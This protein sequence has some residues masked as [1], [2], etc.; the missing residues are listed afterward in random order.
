MINVAKKYLIGDTIRFTGII[1]NLEG[2]EFDPAEVTISVYKKNGDCLLS[3]QGADKVSKG[4]YKYEWTIAGTE[5]NT[6]LM[7]SD[8][9]VVWDWSGPHKKRLIFK[10]IPQV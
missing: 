3:Q 9:I 2:E 1:K 4:N 7:D 5:E 10:V 6:L 8:L